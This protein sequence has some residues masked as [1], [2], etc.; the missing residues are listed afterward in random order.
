MALKI[1]RSK[2]DYAVALKRFEQYSWQKRVCL[3]A[4]RRMCLL[5]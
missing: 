2:K 3:K 5:C 1:I 4:M